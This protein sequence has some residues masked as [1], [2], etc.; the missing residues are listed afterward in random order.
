MNTRVE[1]GLYTHPGF[2]FLDLNLV[3]RLGWV[4]LGWVWFGLV[5]FGFTPMLLDCGLCLACDTR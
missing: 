4:G 1:F 5:W 3:V 2:K